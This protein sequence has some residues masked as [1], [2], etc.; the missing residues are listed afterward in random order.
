MAN[1]HGLQINLNVLRVSR[2]FLSSTGKR[3]CGFDVA[4]TLGIKVSTAYNVLYRMYDAEWISSI[5]EPQKLD[6]RPGS[7]LYHMTP[8]GVHNASQAFAA[9][10]MAST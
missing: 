10:Q 5:Q 8:K 9:L 1:C 6:G 4:K 2:L 3:R 7:R